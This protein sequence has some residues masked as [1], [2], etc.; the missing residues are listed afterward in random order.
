MKRAFL[1]L[2]LTGFATTARAQDVSIT[3][4]APFADAVSV[5]DAIPTIWRDDVLEGNWTTA[6]DDQIEAAVAKAC[7]GGG[8]FGTGARVSFPTARYPICD[9][10]LSSAGVGC[11]GLQLVGSESAARGL[12]GPEFYAV[13][14]RVGTTK[15]D[16][17]IYVE[18]SDYFSMK[19]FIFNGAHTYGDILRLE[20]C[21]FCSITDSY[22]TG[23]R[24]APWTRATSTAGTD[25]IT[26]SDMVTE[27]SVDD[28]IELKPDDLAGAAVPAG[29]T[30]NSALFVKTKVGSNI[31]V[32]TS[33]GGATVD[34]TSSVSNFFVQKAYTHGSG[35]V[36]PAT[37]TYTIAN[38]GLPNGAQIEWMSTA[39]AT[40]TVSSLNF[41]G[42]KFWVIN[43]TP[44]TFQISTTPGGAALNFSG[45]GSANQRFSRV[46][47]HVSG[48][49]LLY[50]EF[51]RNRHVDDTG[52]CMSLQYTN[53]DDPG[54]SFYGANGSSLHDNNFNCPVQL[55]GALTF[56]SNR[57]EGAYGPP[58]A[59]ALD[60][61]DSTSL[62]TNIIDGYFEGVNTGPNAY[63]AVSL[64]APANAVARV[65]RNLVLGVGAS[66][67]SSQCFRL[68]WIPG[69]GSFIDNTCRAVAN[70]FND[71]PLVSYLFA[72]SASTATFSGNWCPS[73]STEG[74]PQP[75]FATAG[76]STR[77]MTS[78][79]YP[80]SR[81]MWRLG[82]S[83]SEPGVEGNNTNAMDFS[84]AVTYQYRGNW[85]LTSKSNENRQGDHK[86]IIA[87]SS[88]FI[89]NSV[90]RTPWG[91]RL[92]LRAGETIHGITERGGTE[93]IEY[94]M[95]EVA[96]QV[97][98]LTAQSADIAATSI[99]DGIPNAGMYRIECYL[100]VTTAGTGGTIDLDLAW[101]D[102]TA[103][104]TRSVIDNLSL[105]TTGY[106][107]ADAVIEADGTND[108]TYAA[109]RT[110]VTGSPVFAIRCAGT[111][112][113]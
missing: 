100:R 85:G 61:S 38:H 52:R 33:P 60:V 112:L 73:G 10:D 111:M 99:F 53:V 56:Y 16:A 1:A 44:N 72:S 64:V 84:E 18:D 14:D 63:T 57:I 65:A 6:L 39:A 68:A 49:S 31:T 50:L 93:Q 54:S 71:P 98:P 69:S 41:W 78:I 106:A 83:V 90:F 110:G 43:P 107:D 15:R 62:H 75:S 97:G 82:G 86:R 3:P 95:G 94:R 55:S 36:D 9:V 17:M 81:M 113:Q 32:A 109:P 35:A 102:G 28:R 96:N 103:A 22:F 66:H 40:S 26:L 11:F 104:R 46:Y 20:V 12:N 29:T 30:A 79:E 2:A 70:C 58:S 42:R 34:L 37:D 67:T 89:N 105:T 92:E 101:N 19:G 7:N 87:E 48:G 47:S 88:G 25:V 80:V 77:P 4:Q 45:S 8:G 76:S 27:F 24:G 13:C 108:V 91:Q 5:F 59:A 21:R 23:L 51:A 74:L